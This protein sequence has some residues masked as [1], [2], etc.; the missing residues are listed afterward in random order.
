[1]EREK[2]AWENIFVLAREFSRCYQN[3]TFRYSFNFVLF[4][5]GMAFFFLFKK[6]LFFLVLFLAVNMITGIVVRGFVRKIL[7]GVET[8]L[9]S[10]VLMG[11]AF[12][13]SMGLVTGIASAAVMLFFQRINLLH[14]AIF[15][16]LYAGVGYLAGYLNEINITLLGIGLSLVY[17]IVSCFFIWSI[18]GKVW[19]C[20]WFTITNLIAN[21]FLFFTF[22]PLLLNI[23]A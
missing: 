13:P 1:M 12:G 6:A 14:V 7:F 5:T 8:I 23:M 9:F 21:G 18:G 15:I 19:K 4:L 20:A 16:P 17:C 11:A 2:N 10:T 3:R 22:A